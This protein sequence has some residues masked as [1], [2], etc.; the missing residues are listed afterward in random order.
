M[1]QMQR[2]YLTK[3]PKKITGITRGND[4]TFSCFFVVENLNVDFA[5][6]QQSQRNSPVNVANVFD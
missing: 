6:I 1:H 5:E 2:N 3:T 4:V